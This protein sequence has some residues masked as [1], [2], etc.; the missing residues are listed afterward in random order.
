MNMDDETLTFYYYNDGLT[1]GERE[2][3]A[4]LLATDPDIANRYQAI[5]QELDRL[6]EPSIT[7]P[8]SDMVERWHDGLDRAIRTESARSRKPVFHTWSFILGA[9]IT[10]ALVVGIGIGTFISSEDLEQPINP[11]ALIVNN[12]NSN[13]FVRGLRVHLRESEQGLATTPFEATSDRGELIR[14]I[15]EQNRRYQALAEQSDSQD[16]A[17]VLR[18][19]D[20]VLVQMA[21]DDITPQEA[22]AL[23]AKLLFELNV[24]L[25]KL[26]RD[27]SNEQL[28]I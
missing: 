5:C 24:V 9:A 20:L 1:S 26:S 7:L 17:R 10:A 19:F 11:E 16:I 3:V 2:K 28:S 12:P 6:G 27:T 8:P 21:A 15:V 4:N 18:A 13:A 23:Q 25:T 14:N 22:K